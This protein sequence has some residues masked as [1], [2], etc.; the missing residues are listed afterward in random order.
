MLR[1]KLL[2]KPAGE[3]MTTRIDFEDRGA[4]V[5]VDEQRIR[6]SQVLHYGAMRDG[7]GVFV[8]VAFN[9]D[10]W[11]FECSNPTE[12]LVAFDEAMKGEP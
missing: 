12:V 9:D 11:L 10:A 8:S 7:S 2:K 5:R 3:N 6:K 4:F 1:A